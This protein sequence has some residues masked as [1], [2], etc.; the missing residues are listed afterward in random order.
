M[1]SPY[2][3]SPLPSLGFPALFP[4]KRESRIR[5][6]GPRLRADDGFLLPSPIGRPTGLPQALFDANLIEACSYFDN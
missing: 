1:P 4:R 5:T 3:L 2:G 6:L